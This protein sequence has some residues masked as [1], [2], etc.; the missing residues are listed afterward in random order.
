MSEGNEFAKMLGRIESLMKHV[1]DRL[2]KLEDYQKKT[3][4]EENVKVVDLDKIKENKDYTKFTEEIKG[5][6]DLMQQTL[7][8][9]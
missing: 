9:N 6:V 7:R 8:K 2:Q 5:N 3:H 4:E 1:V